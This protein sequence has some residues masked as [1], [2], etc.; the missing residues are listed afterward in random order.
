M[1]SYIGRGL[2]SQRRL[3]V[4]GAVCGVLLLTLEAA[5]VVLGW[6]SF[7]VLLAHIVFLGGLWAAYQ[8]FI[9]FITRKWA[10]TSKANGWELS[11]NPATFP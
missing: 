10:R 3:F 7:R 5:S 4:F 9:R 2:L 11:N 6:L 1:R 8:L